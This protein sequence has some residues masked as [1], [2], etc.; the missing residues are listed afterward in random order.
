VRQF[1]RGAA[2]ARRATLDVMRRALEAA[3]V[4]FIENG[5]GPAVWLKRDAG[6]AETGDKPTRRDPLS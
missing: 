2:Q 3:D 1:E 4:E 5:D 6:S